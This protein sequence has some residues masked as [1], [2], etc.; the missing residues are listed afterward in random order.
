M[1]PLGRAADVE[2]LLGS[3]KTDTLIV[4]CFNELQIFCKKGL[5]KKGKYYITLF[6]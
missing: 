1:L 4:H 3:I 6:G 2:I 5:T